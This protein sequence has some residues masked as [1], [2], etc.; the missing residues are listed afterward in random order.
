MTEARWF[1]KGRGLV[2]L[3]GGQVCLHGSMA[4]MRMAAP[5]LALKLG[6]GAFAVGVLLAL[7]SLTQV[8]IAIP[9]GSYADRYGVKRSIGLGT[10][11]AVAGACLAA[12]WPT[13]FV[14]CISALMMGG[15]T[16]AASIALQRHVGR[17]ATD[18][19][20]LKRLFSWVAIGPAVSNF[21]G[22]VLAGVMIDFG[23]MMWGGSTSDT[24]SFQ[25]AFLVM[26]LL[27]MI[28]WLW[29]R[30]IVVEVEI[31]TV[32]AAVTTQVW[33][34]LRRP[35]MRRLLLV[36]WMLSS[37]WD[38]HTFVVPVLGHQHAFSA[39]VIGAILGSFAIAATAVRVVI[40]LLAAHLH[41]WVVL[42]CAMLITST[43]FF[44][45]P[46]MNNVWTMGVCSVLLG[47]AL[48]AV[49][50]MIMS[51]LHQMTPHHLQGQAIA[52]RWMSLNLSSVLMPM[53]FGSLGMAV[54]VSVVF[55]TAG[56]VVGTGSRLAWS[57]RPQ[58]L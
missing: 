37:C 49:Q 46:L 16:G 3:V 35:D 36:N 12:L 6:Y 23:S 10:I 4:G 15:A 50:P 25:M 39:S 40:P 47:F 30:A 42:S 1:S 26:A 32:N 19:T 51:S 53:V 13:F 55:W 14:L 22:P 33:T 8:V 9:A 17:T 27:P 56:V 38:V 20:E 48:G 28:A 34:L 2:G 57:L 44:I 58:S 29:V 11:V 24:G 52:L 18:A 5:L 45:Y 41:E 21:I 31:R 7:F 54:G 43:I